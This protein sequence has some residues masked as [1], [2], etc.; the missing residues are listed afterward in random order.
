MAIRAA[1][2]SLWNL[3]AAGRTLQPAGSQAE[4]S[5]LNDDIARLFCSAVTL[6]WFKSD[7]IGLAH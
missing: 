3:E 2:I 6:I 1:Q 4:T 7:L 5:A